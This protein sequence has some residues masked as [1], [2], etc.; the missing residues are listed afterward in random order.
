[1]LHAVRGLEDLWR[2]LEDCRTA[3]EGGTRVLELLA[4][5][6]QVPERAPAESPALVELREQIDQWGTRPEHERRAW[7]E[8][9]VERRPLALPVVGEAVEPRRP[10]FVPSTVE[11]RAALLAVL[12]GDDAHERSLAASRLLEWPDAHDVWPEVLAA[13]LDGRVQL[14]AAHLSR[15]AP[16]LRAWPTAPAAGERAADLLPWCAP[17]QYRGFVREWIDA[18]EAGDEHAEARL[19]AAPEAMLVPWVL[20]RAE[21]GDGRGARF[22]HRSDSPAVRSIVALLGERSP[23]DV[24]HLR[25]TPADPEADGADDPVDPLVGQGP[26]E[27]VEL[28]ERKG[29]AKGLAVRAVHALVGHEDRAE[30][31][32]SRLVTDRRPAVRSAALRALRKVAPRAVSLAAAARVLSMETRRDVVLQLMKS[33]GHGRHEPSLPA[34]IERLEH[35]DVRVRQGAHDAIMAWGSSVLPALRRATRKARPDRR[36]ALRELVAALEVVDEA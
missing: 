15:L 25:S 18:W 4:E 26:D 21:Q 5:S 36:P 14:L 2:C 30:A 17:W 11:D 28:I 31:P 13:F 19:R 7:L 20:A 27:L 6:L 35:R 9:V 8:A 29:V 34:L 24:E 16:L 33:L 23:G 1:R 10:R 3:P 22:L 32:L 12:A